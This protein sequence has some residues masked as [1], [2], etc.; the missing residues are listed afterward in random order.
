MPPCA[1]YPDLAGK[2][3]LIMG[4]GQVGSTESKIWGNGAAIANILCQNK[5]KIFGCDRDIAAAEFTA[6]RLR[7][8]NGTCDVMVADVTK[9]SDVQKVVEAVIAKYGR[10]DI[11]V[12]NVGITAPGD[13]VS[14]SEEMWDE[15]LKVNLKSV[16]LAC[17]VVLPIME[18]QGSGSVVNNA[19]IAGLRYLGKPQVAYNSAKAAVIHSQ[20]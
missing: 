13:P 1:I 4:I 10:I 18:K 7:E 9:L 17:H 2:I 5:V 20:R 12:N 3:A 14:L 11:L 15:Q 16:Y 8:L 19:S 6:R